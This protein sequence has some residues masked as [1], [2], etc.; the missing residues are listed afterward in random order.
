MGAFNELILERAGAYGDPS[1]IDL[2]VVINDEPDN[3]QEEFVFLDSGG[4]YPKC[5]PASDSRFLL[6]T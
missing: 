6:I 5:K 1:V 2:E 4:E 3:S